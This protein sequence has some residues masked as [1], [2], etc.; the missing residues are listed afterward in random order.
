MN[1]IGL[2]QHSHSHSGNVKN[3]QIFSSRKNS[4]HSFSNLLMRVLKSTG[5]LALR[6]ACA[7]TLGAAWHA[8]QATEPTTASS[9]TQLFQDKNDLEWSGADQSVS[10]QASNGATYWIFED[11]IIGTENASGGYNSGWH[12]VANTILSERDGV[13]KGATASV[14]A[15]P[16]NSDGD[17]YWAAEM[18]ECNGNTYV[19]CS[20][21][22]NVSGGFE[23][24]GTELAKF[25][26]S[27]DMLTFLNRVSTPNTGLVW[28]ATAANAKYSVG[29][30]APGDGYVY[31]FG[32]GNGTHVARVPT[33]NVESAADWR[34]WNGSS[35]VTGMANAA[36]I[37]SP[38]INSMRY[39]QGKWVASW[40]T[41]DNVYAGVATNPYG[42]FTQN[43][44]YASPSGTFDGVSYVTYTASLHPEKVL[45]SGKFLS[46]ICWNGSPN[47]ADVYKPRFTEVTIPGL[48]SNLGGDATF[49]TENLSVAGTSGD[50][51]RTFAYSGFLSGVGTILD[52]T[53]VNDYVTYT[54]PDVPS[55]TYSVRIGVKK[56]TTRGQWQLAI[57]PASG[58]SFTNVGGVQDE[59][60]A[61]EGF[62]EIVLGPW[63]PGTTSDK[64]FKFTVT[65]K[66]ASSTGY[67][68][69]FD[70]IKLVPQ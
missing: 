63:F 68:M 67:S 29:T 64:H 13:L 28:S 60:A 45:A 37:L 58:T 2:P 22:H 70:Y 5:A 66:N 31:F 18:F 59:Y 3:P 52:A 27:G 21:V 56:T 48:L 34:F 51:H 26:R 50:T 10:F 4:V 16:N 61:T 14:P 17:R 12:Y 54:V 39:I 35:W 15:I 30:V 8:T 49:E 23:I 53:G 55:G 19:P 62:Q 46:S 44:L 41:G 25:S 43:L 36:T 24:H 42:P 57:K 69:S 32:A 11:T 7:L 6:T 65:G 38:Q 1:S 47:S 20:K 33:A 40:K 9:W